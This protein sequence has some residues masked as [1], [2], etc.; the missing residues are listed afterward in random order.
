[1]K[2]ETFE[3]WDEPP[4]RSAAAGKRW[5]RGGMVGAYSVIVGQVLAGIWL[6]YRGHRYPAL[7]WVW[8]AVSVV[9]FLGTWSLRQRLW[10]FYTE[11]RVHVAR[12]EERSPIPAYG[13]WYRV[14]FAGDSGPR[15]VTAW[16]NGLRRARAGDEAR[17]LLLD[18]GRRAAVA[19]AGGIFFVRKRRL[20]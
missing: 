12:V 16:A 8:I 15:E 14:S 4:P 7:L 13:C 6:L 1:M 18:D 20:S 9:I 11:G 5:V 10:C 19:I 17:V 2:D 3:A